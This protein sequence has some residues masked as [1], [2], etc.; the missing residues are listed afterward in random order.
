MYKSNYKGRSKP[1]LFVRGDYLNIRTEYIH[2]TAIAKYLWNIDVLSL[3]SYRIFGLLDTVQYS[4]DKNMGVILHWKKKHVIINVFVNK[5]LEPR[6]YQNES[7]DW[8]KNILKLPRFFTHRIGEWK[9]RH[10]RNKQISS[11][12]RVFL[13]FSYL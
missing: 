13:N 10:F 1:I 8:K 3:K 9:A 11:V 5:T 2:C 12:K 4:L 6:K 7:I